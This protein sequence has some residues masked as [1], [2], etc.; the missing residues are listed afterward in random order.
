MT[1]EKFYRAFI[2]NA[3]EKPVV[4]EATILTI[5]N[6]DYVTVRISLMQ[7]AWVL[8]KEHGEADGA[9]DIGHH[10][11]TVKCK[12]SELYNTPEAARKS[13]KAEYRGKMEIACARIA[14]LHLQMESL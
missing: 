13:L 12:S 14:F 11:Y 10:G 3:T 8:P 5:H 4:R 9:E 6:D 1:K 2:H 7:G